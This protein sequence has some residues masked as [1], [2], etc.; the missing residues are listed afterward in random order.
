[1]AMHPSLGGPLQRVVDRERRL[2]LRCKLAACWGFA[3]ALG[4]FLI[5]SE[6]Q[7][8]W[9]SSLALPIIAALGICAA[10]LVWV[11]HARRRP[12]LRRLAAKI[13]IRHPDL[14]GRLVTAVQQEVSA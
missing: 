11:R 13:E 14:D 8:G 9:A 10:L 5:L 3:A 7:S 2:Q 4:A 1:M 6:R 12:D